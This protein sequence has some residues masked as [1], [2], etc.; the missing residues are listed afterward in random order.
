MT[1]FAFKVRKEKRLPVFPGVLYQSF[2]PVSQLMF[3]EHLLK[4]CHVDKV[5]A[6]AGPGILGLL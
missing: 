6:L 3:I 1:I 4:V 2:I 5:S